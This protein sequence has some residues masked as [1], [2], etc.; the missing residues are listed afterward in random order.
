MKYGIRLIIVLV[1]LCNL[2]PGSV[3]GAESAAL[4]QA[5]TEYIAA[6]MPW[7]PDRMR[8][9]FISVPEVPAF[10]KATTLRVE[11]A[12]NGEWIGETA[13]LVRIL[14]G[15]RLVRT[16]TLKARIEVLLDTFAAARPLPAGTVLT[17]ADLRPVSKWV[18][19]IPKEVLADR[20][21]AV[22]RKLTRDC[23]AG[24]ELQRPWLKEVA[25]VKKGKTVK[26][27]F[28]NG[29]MRIVTVGLPEEDGFAGSIVR[30]RNVT[31]NKIIYATV[32]GE[33]LV[34]IEM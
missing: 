17:E 7:S 2:S 30:V 34:G 6:S 26:V 12:G 33:S 31:S 28:D 5:V 3:A 22:G 1:C 21:E 4:Q 29:L 18:H 23:G 32:L 25:L 13:F 10:S 15:N 11:A 8:F 19:R 24:I 27:V 9:E 14:E 16:E 20:G